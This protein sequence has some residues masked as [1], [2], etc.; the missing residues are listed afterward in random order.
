MGVTVL[1]HGDGRTECVGC[2]D[3]I[4]ALRLRGKADELTLP[5]GR[6]DRWAGTI[7]SPGT[8]PRSTDGAVAEDRTLHTFSV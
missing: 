3:N 6:P 1:S 7:P 8:E 5:V 2:A 4:C